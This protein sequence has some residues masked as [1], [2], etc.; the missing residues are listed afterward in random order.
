M[1]HPALHAL[2]P[3]ELAAMTGGMMTDFCYAGYDEI[4]CTLGGILGALYDAF[5]TAPAS[6]YAYGKV[7]YSQ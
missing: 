7:G 5:R 3:E 6:S 1:N 4:A 2:A